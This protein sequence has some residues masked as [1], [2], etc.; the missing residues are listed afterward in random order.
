LLNQSVVTRYYPTASQELAASHIR[1]RWRLACALSI[2]PIVAMAHNLYFYPG[3]CLLNPFGPD[4]TLD[5]MKRLL[6]NDPALLFGGFL[7]L[8]LYSTGLRLGWLR[9]LVGPF[10]VSFAPLCFWIWDIPF[11]GRLICHTLHDGRLHLF[12]GLS[13]RSRH[14]FEL[15]LLLYVVLV[16]TRSG[17]RHLRLRTLFLRLF[18]VRSDGLIHQASRIVEPAL[19][20]SSSRSAPGAAL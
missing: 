20:S 4:Y 7:S 1:W 18:G 11:T 10:L 19:P 12:N 13:L 17:Y 14:L 16:A 5:V 3:M 8:A 2:F 15:G 6:S 9:P